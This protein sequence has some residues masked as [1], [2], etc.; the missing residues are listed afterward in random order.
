MTPY[1]ELR[2]YGLAVFGSW[3]AD[4]VPGHRHRLAASHEQASG[5]SCPDRADHLH[6]GLAVDDVRLRI[7]SHRRRERHLGTTSRL[8][9]K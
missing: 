3:R 8:S 7:R 5:A 2:R 6:D 1:I 4:R 9:D